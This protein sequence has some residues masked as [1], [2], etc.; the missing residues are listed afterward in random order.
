MVN[1]LMRLSHGA[2]SSIRAVEHFHP[3]ETGFSNN[4]YRKQRGGGFLQTEGSRQV[5]PMCLVTLMT[6]AGSGRLSLLDFRPRGPG[7]V[8][9]WGNSTE[10]NRNPHFRSSGSERQQVK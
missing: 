5:G 6:A 9:G 2:R 4:H 7:V 10:Q 8:R 1:E 3:S